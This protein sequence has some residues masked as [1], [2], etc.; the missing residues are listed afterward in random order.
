[1]WK[2][3]AWGELT[4]TWKQRSAIHPD[5]LDARKQPLKGTLI[6]YLTSRGLDKDS[7][8]VWSLTPH[9]IK[10]IESGKTS[11]LSGT[12]KG[13]ANRLDK[14][15][16][17]IDNYRNG[18]D[19]S[20][21]SVTQRLEFWKCALA[22]IAE[23]PINGVGTGDVNDKFQQQYEASQSQLDKAFR[24]RSHNQYLTYSVAL[25][26][27]GGLYLIMTLLYPLTRRRFRSDFLYVAFATVSILSFMTEDSLET[28]AGVTFFTFFSCMLLF[29]K[30]ASEDKVK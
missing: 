13:L 18:G 20:G 9:D 2:H 3:I 10:M 21:N 25:G 26:I 6:R 28:Q 30:P 27:P 16:F 5:S 12:K 1:V 11:Y 24:L 7:V 22:I 8:G 14:I 17:E 19:P 29:I 4:R 23:N 15:F